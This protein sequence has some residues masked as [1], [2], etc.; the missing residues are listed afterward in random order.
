MSDP[1]VLSGHDIVCLSTI[2]WQF[3]WQGHQEVM[4]ALAANG[5]RVLFVENTGVRAASIRDLPR[6]RQRIANWRR[7]TKGFRLERENLFVYSPILLPFPYSRLAGWLNRT[8]LRRSLGRW[9]RAA[10]FDRPIVW[11]F[12]PTPLALHIIRALDPLVTIY[13]CIDDLASSSRGARRIAHSEETLFREADLVFVTS[14]RL[15]KRASALSHHVHLFPFAVSYAKFDRVREAPGG[16]PDDLAALPRPIVGYVG[17]VHQWVDF[18]L[19]REVAIA[20]PDTS[21]VFVGPL[22]A[23]ASPISGVPNVHLLGQRPHDDVPRYIKGFDVGIVPYLLSEYTA[24]VYPTKL[25][26]Y[27]AMGLPVVATDLPEIQRFNEEHADVVAVA[28]GADEFVAV[29]R[30]ALQVGAGHDSDRRV[31]V[32]RQNTWAARL[33][34]MSRLVEGIIRER[35][36]E[37]SWEQRLK[38]LYRVSRRRAGV[39]LAGAILLY[40]LLF[41]TGL[42]WWMAGPL[43]RVDSPRK[44]DAIVVFAGGVGESG[45]AGGGYQERV[46]QAVDLYRQGYAARVIISSGFVFAFSEAQVMRDLAVAQGVPADAILLETAAA[47]TYENVRFTRTLLAERGWRR[48]LLVSSPYHMRRATMTWKRVAPDIDVIASPVEESQFYAHERGASLEQLRGLLH[49]VAAIVVYW[50]KGWI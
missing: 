24:N 3:I 17:G 18:E 44:A 23:D 34:E 19:V 25:N 21:F 20:M 16:V 46:K 13:Y 31:A 30:T 41:E 12:L 11:T 27:L 36:R 48:I 8:L 35:P 4:S 47:N 50:W 39:S 40:A 28:R 33:A 1:S 29:T 42:P 37:R 38:R 5:N 6:V 45:V 32:A 26:E 22:Q 14:E 15:R 2:D 43:K 49:E 7:G 9:M 10:R